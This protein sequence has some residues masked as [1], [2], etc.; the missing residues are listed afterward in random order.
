MNYRHA[1]PRIP[2]GRALLQNG[3]AKTCKG[4][5]AK[6]DVHAGSEILDEPAGAYT[7]ASGLHQPIACTPARRHNVGWFSRCAEPGEHLHEHCKVCGLQWLTA[8]AGEGA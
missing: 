7:K 4:C 2:E 5:G 3:P 8:F 6:R 1:A